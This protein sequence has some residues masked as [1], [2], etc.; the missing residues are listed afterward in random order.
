MSNN[1]NMNTQ[2]EQILQ[3]ALTL[4][5]DDRVEIAESLILSLDE[6]R[7]ADIE[8]AWAEEIKCRIESID[9]G[10]VQLIPAD[11]VMREMRERLN[12]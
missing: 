12:G 1:I 10:Q 9:N 3:I 6:K 4:D 7:A 8:A 11:Q 2:A 5:P